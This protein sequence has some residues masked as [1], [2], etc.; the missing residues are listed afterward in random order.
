MESF[1]RRRVFSKYKLVLTSDLISKQFGF[2]LPWILNYG[3]KT[4]GFTFLVNND[5]V[6]NRE[7]ENAEWTE[8]QEGYHVLDALL[9]QCNVGPVGL[10]DTQ[11]E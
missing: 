9:N 2:L 6:E 3:Q 5:E 8:R 7:N 4:F 1:C 11:S 10:E